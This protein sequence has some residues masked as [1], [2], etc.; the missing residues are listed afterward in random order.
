M[1]MRHLI[2][3]L[4]ASVFLLS[5]H[6]HSG[7]EPG[8]NVFR[9]NDSSGISTLD[10]AFARDQA[11]IWVCNQLFN[12]LVQLDD[13]L[14]IKP[15]IAHSWLI[16]EDGLQYT[17]F[18]R[19]DVYFHD[20]PSFA[21]GK[22]RRVVAHDFVYSFARLLNPAT[23]SPGAWVFSYVDSPAFV[24]VND[25]VLKIYLKQAFPPFLGMLSMQY[26]SVV[27]SE[28]I[29]KTGKDFRM[30]PVG[31]G[32]FYFKYWKEGSK[33][34][35]LKNPRYFE[36]D[37]NGDV[38]PHLDA[39]NISFIID[40]QSAFL[41]FVKGNLDF[42][43]GLDASYKDE[44]IS[45]SG[46]LSKKYENRFNLISQPYLNMEYLGIQ[47]APDAALASDA[48]RMKKVRQ[49]INYGFDRSK[50]L[51]YMRNNIGTPG[52]Y[53]VIPPGLPS[54]QPDTFFSYDPA[55]SA[56]LLEEAGFP[57]GAGL[58]EIKLTTTSSYLDLCIYIQHQLQELGIRLKVETSPPASLR[59]MVAYAKIPFF[60][61]SWIADYP[62][63]ENYLSLFFSHNFCPN[64]PN[65]T[66]FSSPDFDKLYHQSVKEPNDSV[67]H[68]LYAA[69]NAIVMEEAPV[70]ILYYDQ[71]LRFVQ[72]NVVGLGSN[73]LNL[74]NL[75]KVRKAG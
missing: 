45:R 47:M 39:V 5:C 21:Q 24:A 64:G 49:A 43:S 18:L 74:L 62:D 1:N 2:Y 55:L 8:A 52:I 23:A 42:L 67:R 72:K 26:C 65:Y 13:S 61:A 14:H 60:R 69:M 33:L 17:F 37:E 20:H 35:L 38:L 22:G 29:L 10:P 63:A 11:I 4:L 34:V 3:I 58:P 12:G 56:R 36:K 7:R 51:K 16:S 15:S 46:R 31:T 19:N 6:S 50:M 32:P 59:E 75:K 57:R 48:L 54:F 28:V 68:T 30:S 40:K 53:G 71:V 9:Y 41:E 73:P 70:V 66:R 27:P 44:L 25:S